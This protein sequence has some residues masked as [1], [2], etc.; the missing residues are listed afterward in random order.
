MR[1]IHKRDIFYVVL[2]FILFALFFI[3]KR[4][5]DFDRPNS[6]YIEIPAIVIGVLGIVIIVMGIVNLDRN[7]TPF[8]TPRKN[9]KL[10]LTGIYAYIRH[11]IYSGILIAM[12]GYT[13]YTLSVERLIYT[14]L[15]LVVFYFKSKVEEQLLL[16]KFPYYK[17]Y[18]SSTGRFFPRF[19]GR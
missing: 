14:L 11:P 9:S 18:L 8:P 19:F 13:V 6:P 10:I 7:L 1:N 3:N 2:Q 16:E 5:I 17:D 12:L 15:M 4:F